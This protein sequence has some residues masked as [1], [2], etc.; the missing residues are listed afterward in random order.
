MAST[1][2]RASR[3]SVIGDL[4]GTASLQDPAN[5]ECRCFGKGCWLLYDGRVDLCMEPDFQAWRAKGLAGLFRSKHGFLGKACKGLRQH[6]VKPTPHCGINLYPSFFHCSEISSVLHGVNIH[7]QLRHVPGR[8]KITQL[9][10]KGSG[11]GVVRQHWL[12]IRAW[13]L[14]SWQPSP[15]RD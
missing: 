11:Y 2:T 7:R 9:G 4:D 10:P 12:Y 3:T 13:I 14:Q 8:V 6:R 5:R 1:D 15:C